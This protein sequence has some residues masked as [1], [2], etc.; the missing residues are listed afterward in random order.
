M[1]GSGD[2]KK[3]HLT[4]QFI[5][6]YLLFNHQA[7]LKAALKDEKLFYWAVKL[8]SVSPEHSG[9]HLSSSPHFTVGNE[10]YV[11]SKT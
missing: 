5:H 9:A 7:K 6:S 3:K 4:H 1:W 8:Y 10:T 2:K 11:Y